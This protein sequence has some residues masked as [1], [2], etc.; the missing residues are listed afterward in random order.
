MIPEFVRA[1]RWHC[2]VIARRL[3]EQHKGIIVGLGENVHAKLREACDA[4]SWRVAWKIDGRVVAI[5]GIVGPLLSTDGNAWAALTEEASAHPLQFVR[6]ARRQLREVAQIK[7]RLTTYVFVADEP[8]VRF[9]QF[10]GFEVSDE[11]DI[12]GTA[13]FTMVADLKR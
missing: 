7:H 2:G 6:L 8:S 4:S 9:A 3:R 5:S 11:T 12:D 1:E 13:V 10:M